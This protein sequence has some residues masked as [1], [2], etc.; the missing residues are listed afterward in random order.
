MRS[1]TV[2]IA[3]GL[4]SVCV[5]GSASGQSC[6]SVGW[7]PEFYCPLPW[8][9]SASL[10]V[11]AL[12]PL[13]RLI[14]QGYTGG[15]ASQAGLVAWD[16]AQA[17][18]FA[19]ADGIGPEVRAAVVFDAD[20][21][22]PQPARLVVGG[23]FNYIGGVSATNVAS[24]DGQNWQP[25]GTGVAGQVWCLGVIP[26]SGSSPP[27]LCAGG[28]A[29]AG[30]IARWTGTQWQTMGAGLAGGNVLTLTTFDSGS[31]PELYAG[32]SFVL[33]GGARSV[34]RWN[35]TSWQPLGVLLW[36]SAV[37]AIYSLA[38]H[39]ADGP[40]PQ[41]PLLYL[42]G[43][44]AGTAG[45]DSPGVIA[46]NGSAFL[47]V[48]GGV[49]HE[50]QLWSCRLASFDADG[51][52]PGAAVLCAAGFFTSAGG[53]PVHNAAQWDGTGW[54][55]MGQ[56]LDVARATVVLDFDGPGPGAPRLCVAGAHSSGSVPM[57]GLAQWD[58]ESW[59]AVDGP[60][61]PGNGQGLAG[62][63][64][65]LQVLATSGGRE[66]LIVAG[67]FNQAGGGPMGSVASW[68]GQA[69]SSLASEFTGAVSTALFDDD[70]PGPGKTAVWVGGSFDQLSGIPSR[71]LCA[72]SGNSWA[73]TGP[74]LNADGGIRAM[75]AAEVGG[76]PALVICGTFTSIDGF[77]AD[78][79]AVRSGGVWSALGAPPVTNPSLLTIWDRD[80]AGP[81]GAVVVT[82]SSTS[83][84]FM[85]DDGGWQTIPQPPF[86]VQAIA[87]FDLDGAG[88]DP[89]RL[90]GA[91]ADLLSGVCGFFAWNG[92]SWSP[93]GRQ[94]EFPF[95][96]NKFKLLTTGG[97]PGLYAAGTFSW[98]TN[99]ASVLRW[100]GADWE[101]VADGTG[102]N[103]CAYFRDDPHQ[104]LA[105]YVA[106][107]NFAT[108]VG[109]SRGVAR[110]GCTGTTCYANCDQSTEPPVLNVLDF[111]CFLNRFTAG[112]AYANCDGST[113]P[114]ALNV[115]DFNCF[116]NQ[117]TGGCP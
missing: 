111:N 61:G 2:R 53:V 48:G 5:L 90:I 96:V 95:G 35:G 37:A 52:G 51:P 100:D 24:W 75:I 6:P 64:S 60:W 8:N 47:P 80:G 34:A 102:A 58:G 29:F 62:S 70:G 77:P 94:F 31:G 19:H 56:G 85:W 81:A 65:D 45:V 114:P 21:E 67:S 3:A 112:D 59:S 79:V 49:R 16:S 17:T 20:G 87:S 84:L 54:R 113:A 22:G 50:N 13:Q 4:A 10:A 7:S 15:P 42:G 116:L 68:D 82:G 89:P 71:G 98:G 73:A 39:D 46:W 106:V 43:S 44:H 55:P 97:S 92:S 93:V 12:G 72:W 36:N 74:G 32:G 86:S 33:A 78:R 28:T 83:G 27:V 63:A 1:G 104:P 57:N 9:T 109:T 105:L 99:H 30:N 41:P 88:A 40:G 110:F 103:S 26:A 101:A 38:V 117:Y 66:E 115:L 23:S 11:D 69:W 107:D 14:F 18:I 91:C 25:L 108:P 76:A